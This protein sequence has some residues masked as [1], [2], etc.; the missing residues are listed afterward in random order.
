MGQFGQAYLYVSHASNMYSQ[1]LRE[2]AVHLYVHQN[3]SFRTVADLLKIDKSTLHRWIHDGGTKTKTKTNSSSSKNLVCKNDQTAT[4]SRWLHA[5]LE[6]NPFSTCRS[7]A[8]HLHHDFHLSVSKSTIHRWIRELNFTRKIPVQL[9]SSPELEQRR[10][11]W[12][13]LHCHKFQNPC[14]LVSIDETAFYVHSQP[15]KGYALRGNRLILPKAPQISRP[16]RVSVIMAVSR[17]KILKWQAFHGAIDGDIFAD[18]MSKLRI[19]PAS[20]VLMDNVS[21]HRSSQV[22]VVLKAKHVFPLFIPPYTPD[23]NPIEM[24]FGHVKRVYKS[25]RTATDIEAKIEN[26]IQSVTACQLESAFDFS[27]H[28][29]LQRKT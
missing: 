7:L 5:Q 3:F 26:A 4:V 1:D 18:F 16:R 25:K 21:F 17:T 13:D 23:F 10:Q 9:Y 22:A 12:C 15:T 24:I 27:L 20:T 2:R 6:N 11:A 8:I 29:V 14:R 28:S 19:P